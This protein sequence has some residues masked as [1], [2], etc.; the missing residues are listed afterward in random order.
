[1]KWSVFG[2]SSI[3]NR[4]YIKDEMELRLEGIGA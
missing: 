3:A 4:S 2:E 1:M